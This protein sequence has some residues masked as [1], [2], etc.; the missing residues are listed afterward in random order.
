M[1]SALR[2]QQQVAQVVEET[3]APVSMA[4]AAAAAAA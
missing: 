1:E 3:E 2:Y 4:G